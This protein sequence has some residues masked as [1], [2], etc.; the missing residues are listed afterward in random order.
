[1]YILPQTSR[2]RR[3]SKTFRRGA[4]CFFFPLK[5]IVHLPCNVKPQQSCSCDGYHVRGSDLEPCC[6]LSGSHPLSPLLDTSVCVTVRNSPQMGINRISQS[7]TVL[8][9]G[10]E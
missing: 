7:L 8:L 9:L 6:L 5:S 3:L 10:K 4:D 2:D 1:M